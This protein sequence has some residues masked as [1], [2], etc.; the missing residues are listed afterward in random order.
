VTRQRCR[1]ADGP[2]SLSPVRGTRVSRDEIHGPEISGAFSL[3]SGIVSSLFIILS[4]Q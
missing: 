3:L 2:V 1:F 4:P